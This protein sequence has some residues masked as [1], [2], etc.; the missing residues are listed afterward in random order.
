MNKTDQ[1]ERNLEMVSRVGESWM[2][3]RDGKQG[4]HS[5]KLKFHTGKATSKTFRKVP[6]G[7]DTGSHPQR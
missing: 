7:F 4:K 3:E 5:E 2:V 6:F 1:K